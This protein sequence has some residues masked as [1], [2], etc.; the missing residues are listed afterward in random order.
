VP[1]RVVFF[2]GEEPDVQGPFFGEL[3]LAADSLEIRGE[4]EVKV[5]LSAV[6]S[7]SLLRRNGQAVSIRVRTVDGHHLSFG[8]VRVRLGRTF[9]MTHFERTAALFGELRTW[10]GVSPAPESPGEEQPGG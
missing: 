8:V 1:D 6:R 4:G 10:A 3:T 9:V 5:P 7:A 2:T